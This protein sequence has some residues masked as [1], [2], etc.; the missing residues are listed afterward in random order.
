[1]FVVFHAV[2]HL[3]IMI[4]NLLYNC[5]PYNDLEGYFQVEDLCKFGLPP[6]QLF[7]FMK[8][9]LHMSILVLNCGYPNNSFNLYYKL[10]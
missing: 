5:N 4:S 9:E 2:Y 7:N 8:I 3:S 10:A 1:M 6:Y